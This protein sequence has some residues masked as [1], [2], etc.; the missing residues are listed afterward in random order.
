MKTLSLSDMATYCDEQYLTISRWIAEGKLKGHKS[1]G[2]GNY[3]VLFSDFLSFLQEQKL[4]VP[5]ELTLVTSNSQTKTVL[6]VDD[7]AAMRNAVA[8]ALKPLNLLLEQAVDGF[9]AGVKLIQLNPDVLILDLA[10]PG[11]DG[12]ELLQHIKQ[13]PHLRCLKVLVLS[14]LDDAALKK[15]YDYGADAVLAK[16]FENEE[17]QCLVV[18]LLAGQ[19]RYAG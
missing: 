5:Q 4:P 6:I 7:E 10:I 17:L 14:G 1:L 15:A 12:Y 3:R 9:H 11:L 13:E 18:G 16:P 8:R 2:R 19:S